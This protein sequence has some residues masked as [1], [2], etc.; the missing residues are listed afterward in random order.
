M[1]TPLM[2]LKYYV[3]ENI[4]ESQVFAPGEQILDFP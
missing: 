4:M 1:I 3:F 2:P